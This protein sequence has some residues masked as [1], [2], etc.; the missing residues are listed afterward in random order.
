MGRGLSDIQKQILIYVR[1]HPSDRLGGATEWLGEG[2]PWRSCRIDA[3]IFGWNRYAWPKA[4]Q[5]ERGCGPN[6]MST[7]S[8]AVRRL[9]ERG[10]IVRIR[11]REAYLRQLNGQYPRWE[12]IHW[13]R[14]PAI[15]LTPEGRKV[16][17]SLPADE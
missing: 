5:E 13:H 2:D 1:D 11:G 16:A 4:A 8:R 12:K 9:E 10:L 14:T 7:L 15:A 3:A 17:E 6:L